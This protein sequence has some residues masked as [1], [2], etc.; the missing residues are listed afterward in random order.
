[1]TLS[2][3]LLCQKNKSKIIVRITGDC[4]LA[5]PKIVDKFVKEF[6]KSKIDYISNTNPWTYPDGFDVEVFS[7]NLLKEANK[8]AKK[9]IE[10]VEC[11]NLLFK[12]Q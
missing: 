6:K 10:K 4:P 7:F 2:K 11:F 1:M 3:I 5:D 9:N 8:K 12:R